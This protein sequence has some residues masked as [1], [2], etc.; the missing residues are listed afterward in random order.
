[1]FDTG[2]T[3]NVVVLLAAHFTPP[4]Q[5][6]SGFTLL[7][8]GGIVGI[9]RRPDDDRLRALSR[10]GGLS[11]LLFP[12]DIDK[13]VD[14]V[15][16]LLDE[17]F[18]RHPSAFVVGPLL[19]VG[20]GSP[21]VVVAT[22]G[23][24]V[25]DDAVTLIGRLLVTLPHKDVALTRL[26][27]LVVGRFDAQGVAIDASLVDSKIAETPVRGDMRLRVV[28]TGSGSFAFSAGGFH[29]AFPVPAGMA[30]MR[31]LDAA[32]SAGPIFRAR[33]EAYVALTTNS[34]QVGARLDLRASIPE[35]EIRGHAAF[36]AL[37]RFDPF[38]FET[39]IDASVTVTAAGVDVL[40]VTLHLDLSGPSPW[41]VRGHA[42]ITLIVPVDIDIPTTHW[43]STVAA[44]LPPARSPASVLLHELAVAANW[45]AAPVGGPTLVALRPGVGDA[46]V[47]P[48]A[49]S[50]G[51]RQRAVPLGVLLRRMDG[52]RLARP[53]RL[54][55]GRD[56]SGGAAA[57]LPLAG[58]ESFV[59]QQFD[60][61]SDDQRL[62][63]AGFE[64]WSC[65]VELAAGQWVGDA[66][67][68][69]QTDDYET[70]LLDL[71]EGGADVRPLTGDGTADAHVI[72]GHRVLT[73]LHDALVH[74]KTKAVIPA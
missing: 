44:P 27:A 43:G 24:L 34:A 62:A 10:S 69:S 21:T 42:T 58:D 61:L 31:R 7:D 70:W 38:M 39:S 74:V 64:R 29:P 53:S 16:H 73:T 72:A 45:T 66:T 41:R 13:H 54:A 46:A 48:L 50:L 33:L 28:T 35:F 3:P 71:V 49:P 56:G 30:G 59:R 4:I 63:G 25:S 52:V 55:L 40:G 17:C 14:S 15:I 68:A 22:I 47:H 67:P 57:D 32:I 11:G 20:W 19:R 2:D 5:L 65:G 51:F 23:A 6:S 8:V 36:D 26:E 37:F 12:A 18:P 9:N 1:M 60:D